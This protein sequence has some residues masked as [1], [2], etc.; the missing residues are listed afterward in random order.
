VPPAR[1]VRVARRAERALLGGLM[2]VLARL[3]ER[4]LARMR[5]R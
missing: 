2:A 4:K 3:F 1:R 5:R